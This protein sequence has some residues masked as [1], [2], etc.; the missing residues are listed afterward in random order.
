VLDVNQP[1]ASE[2]SDALL[3]AFDR[4]AALHADPAQTAYRLFHG[5][6]EGCPGLTVD[7]LGPALV[8]THRSELEAVVPE[9]LQP[10]VARLVPRLVV[11]KLRQ[12]K[13]QP[14]V[15]HGLPEKLVEVVDNG[16]RFEIEPLAP[17]NEG[18]YLDARPARTWLLA[19]STERRI[20]NLFAY[21][22]SLGIAAASGGARWVIHVELQKRQLR[23][24]KRNLS[25]NGLPV[26]D[27]NL[28]REDLYKYLRRVN[29]KGLAVDGVILDP[30]PMVPG[31]G[32]QGQDYASLT[33]LAAPL[34]APG[35]WLLCFF[36]RRERS[37]ADSEQEVL[38]ASP[39][40]LEVLHRG[41]SGDEFPEADPE[42]RLRFTAFVRP[43]QARELAPAQDGTGRG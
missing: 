20:L 3:A 13:S 1:A 7:R 18:L 32:P 24:I 19:N 27:R 31:R 4:R 41:T 28:V 30:P 11:V 16:L 29:K 42:A 39:F 12:G 43:Q 34:L 23:R 17:R 33:R 15:V 21:T 5:H 35:G 14:R 2:L 22:G 26:D 37:R 6:G 36:H 25:L 40:P 9:G 10:L 38:D 8:V